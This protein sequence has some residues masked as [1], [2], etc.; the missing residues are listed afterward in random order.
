MLIY[1]GFLPLSNFI[2]IRNRAPSHDAKPNP[3]IDAK[4]FFYLNA[5]PPNKRAKP[6]GLVIDFF[7]L[8]SKGP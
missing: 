4:P 1:H 6:R 7:W 8:G 2:F 5:K 3:N